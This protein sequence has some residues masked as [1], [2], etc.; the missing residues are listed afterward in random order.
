MTDAVADPRL[1]EVGVEHLVVDRGLGLVPLELLGATVVTSVRVDGDDLDPGV[2]GHGEDGRRPAS[3]RA[4]L[5]DPVTL[6]QQLGTLPQ[7]AS[8]PF[9]HPAVDVGDRSPG[10][11]ELSSTHM[12][13]DAT[14]GD[15]PPHVDAPSPHASSIAK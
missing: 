13:F 9:G 14:G 4:D 15:Y 2:G 6:G 11:G 1:V 8:L 5:D 3:K 10:L 12:P 7:T